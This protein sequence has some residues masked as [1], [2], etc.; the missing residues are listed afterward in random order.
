MSI[1]GNK[2]WLLDKVHVILS[3]GTYRAQPPSKVVQNGQTIIWDAHGK[4]LKLTDLRVYD[5][6]R[7]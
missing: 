3:N 6:V 5:D 7:R 2:P 1:E 4:P